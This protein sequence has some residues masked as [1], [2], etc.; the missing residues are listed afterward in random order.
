M[1]EMRPEAG[2]NV[3]IY[4]SIYIKSGKNGVLA[5]T[6]LIA[7]TYKTPIDTNTIFSGLAMPKQKFIN[8]EKF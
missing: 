6:A 4:A 3:L 7:R 2:F 1:K 5:K 8:I